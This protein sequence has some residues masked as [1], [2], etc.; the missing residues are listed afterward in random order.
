MENKKYYLCTN[1]YNEI[2]TNIV[3][4]AMTI[5]AWKKWMIQTKL[6]WIDDIGYLFDDNAM[7]DII[8]MSNLKEN[9]VIRFVRDYFDLRII[10]LEDDTLKYIDMDDREKFMSEQDVRKMCLELEQA[11][12]FNNFEDFRKGN[13]SIGVHFS[14]IED[15]LHGD[16]DNVLEEIGNFGAWVK[17][18]EFI[19]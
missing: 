19:G 4:K 15:C 1:D 8:K 7:A 3:G 13:L 18:I 14:N 2:D 10:P 9:D 16:I 11:D 12:L 5:S 17:K 6:A